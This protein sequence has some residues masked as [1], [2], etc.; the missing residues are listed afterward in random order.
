MEGERERECGCVCV[1]TS[2]SAGHAAA[3]AIEK[4]ERGREGKGVESG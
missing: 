3:G 2:D 1:C 4:G